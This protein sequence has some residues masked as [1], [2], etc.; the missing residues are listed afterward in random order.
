MSG[1]ATAMPSDVFLKRL[2]YWLPI[3][4]RMIR[5]AWG[6]TM[7]RSS[8]ALV[9]PSAPPA[10]DWPFETARMP[11]R[12]ISAMNAAVYSV[13]PIHSEKKPGV[14]IRPLLDSWVKPPVPRIST[15][16]RANRSGLSV[17]P[18]SY[19]LP[20]KLKNASAMLRIVFETPLMTRKKI[21]KATPMTPAKIIR[22]QWSSVSFARPAGVR[23]LSR[24]RLIQRKANPT[25]AAARITWSSH[26][27]MAPK[28]LEM[29]SQMPPTQKTTGWANQPTMAKTAKV[30]NAFV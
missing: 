15:A 5:K 2:R 16:G 24:K 12:T 14:M 27:G 21:A 26:V 6:R 17:K 20:R 18:E 13:T 11:P 23:M 1:Y 28:R 19:L 22:N 7:N 29:A 8:C 10:S 30:P 9:R 4:G 25:A 3:G